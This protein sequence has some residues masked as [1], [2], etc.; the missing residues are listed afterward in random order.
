M[1]T[2]PDWRLG[3]PETISE[4]GFCRGELSEHQFHVSV[5]PYKPRPFLK[6]DVE[7][8]SLYIPSHKYQTLKNPRVFFVLFSGSVTVPPIDMANLSAVLHLVVGR[9]FFSCLQKYIVLIFVCAGP[10]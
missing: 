7:A 1:D 2:E 10:K 5:W 3:R 6:D 8:P 9:T 4:T